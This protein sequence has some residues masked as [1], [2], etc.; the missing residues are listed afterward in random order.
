MLRKGVVETLIERTGMVRWGKRGRKER[1]LVVSR[2]GFS[3]SCIEY[4]EKE[5]VMYW[6]PKDLKTLF[7]PKPRKRK[8]K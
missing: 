8:R 3:K 4:M 7:W 6:A 5:G 1:Y 2:G